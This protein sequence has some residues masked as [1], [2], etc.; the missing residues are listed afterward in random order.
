MEVALLRLDVKTILQQPLKYLPDVNPVLLHGS[1]EDQNVININEYRA[2][3][4]VPEDIVYQR[5][6]DSW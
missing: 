1:R 4:H 6:E 3:Q 2:V 5:L